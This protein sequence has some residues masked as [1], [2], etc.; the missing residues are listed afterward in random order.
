MQQMGFKLW[1]SRLFTSSKELNYGSCLCLNATYLY[2]EAL[3]TFA[4]NHSINEYSSCRH[5]ICGVGEWYLFC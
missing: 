5:R 1:L 4:E 3:V 2:F